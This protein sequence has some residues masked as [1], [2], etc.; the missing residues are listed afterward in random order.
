GADRDD[1]RRELLALPGM[2]AATA[3]LIRVRA[4]GDPDV[5]PPGF[6]APDAWRPWRTYAFQHLYTAG[7][8]PR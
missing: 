6:P 3:A 2:D 1:A 5:A 7:E 4:L 8:L